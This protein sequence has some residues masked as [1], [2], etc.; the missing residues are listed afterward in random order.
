MIQFQPAAVG[1]RLFSQQQFNKFSLHHLQA[2]GARARTR[3]LAV[4]AYVAVLVDRGKP[5][6]KN[7]C[8]H[9][10]VALS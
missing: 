8:V 7:K 9:V 6:R 10:R 4:G 3:S 1:G 5:I 2:E